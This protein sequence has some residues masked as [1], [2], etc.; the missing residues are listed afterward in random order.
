[1]KKHFGCLVALLLIALQFSWHSVNGQYEYVRSVSIVPDS[2]AYW[3]YL[4][5]G[6][7]SKDS[8]KYPLILYIH[9]AGDY[10]NGTPTSMKLVLRAGPLR[11]ISLNQFPQTFT[12]NG[13]TYGFIV[14]APQFMLQPSV[15][16]INSVINF[17][18]ATYK[19]DVS[20]IYLTGL[21]MGGAL[22][23]EYSGMQAAYA[24]RLAG[25][26]PVCGETPPDYNRG[27][28]IAASNLPVWATHNDG[29]PL[30]PVQWSIQ[31]IDWINDPPPPNLLAML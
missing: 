19:V 3:E 31:Q 27:R 20:R 24:N 18:I 11:Y 21:S 10:G 6:Y 30:A 1:M 22:S 5:V 29:D 2:K 15:T 25:I 12:V 8:L 16:D 9:G 26:V 28:V 17:C 4:P 23:W 7:N 14:I 13:K